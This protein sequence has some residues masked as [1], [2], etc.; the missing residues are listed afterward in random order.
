MELWGIR[1]KE[2]RTLRKRNRNLFRNRTSVKFL[3]IVE[4]TLDVKV[5]IPP[6][7]QKVIDKEKWSHRSL[8]TMNKAIS[9]YLKT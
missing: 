2:I 8:A 3:D 1:I 4:E 9:E 7:I 6:Q 5:E